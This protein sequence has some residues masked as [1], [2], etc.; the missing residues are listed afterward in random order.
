[1][2]ELLLFDQRKADLGE[3][4]LRVN[5]CKICTLNKFIICRFCTY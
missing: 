1:M 4:V 5:K 3:T 2:H